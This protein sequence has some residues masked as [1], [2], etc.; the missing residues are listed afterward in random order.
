MEVGGEGD[1][2][3]EGSTVGKA[4]GSRWKICCT[5]GIGD[6]RLPGRWSCW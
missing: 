1:T 2:A 5:L 4:V 3:L 6:N